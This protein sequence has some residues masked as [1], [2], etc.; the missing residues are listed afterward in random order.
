LGSIDPSHEFETFKGDVGEGPA[1]EFCGFLKTFRKLPSVDTILLDP[2][3]AVVPDDP[4]TQYALCGALAHK[5]SK[6]NFSRVITYVQRLPAEFGV[7]F[8]RDILKRDKDIANT[9]DFIRWASGPGGKI[10]T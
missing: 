2:K 7:L 3:G 8:V 9:K 1:G 4:S 10:L 6:D 5:T